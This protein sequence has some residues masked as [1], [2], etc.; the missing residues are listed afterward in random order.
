MYTEQRG[1][2]LIELM[3][4][5]AIVGILAAVAI[6]AY[7]DYIARS[8]ASE[9]VTV[10]DALKA[11]IAENIQ[12]GDCSDQV[13]VSNNTIT[14]K[15]AQM[16][17]PAGVPASSFPICTLIGTYGNGSA[18]SAVSTALTQSGANQMILGM[19]T[20]G[21]WKNYGSSIPTKYIP[22]AQLSN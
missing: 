7:M 10:A 17:I 8:Q 4:V 21:S 15:Y 11:A 5:V 18:G 3:I 14:G 6:P 16:T 12:N 19:N 9:V 13:T 22:K 2:T 1:F 20:N